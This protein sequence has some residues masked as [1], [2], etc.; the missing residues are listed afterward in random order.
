MPFDILIVGGG[1][2]GLT[3]AITLRAH[4]HHVTVLEKQPTL[5]RSAGASI[6]LQPGAVRVLRAYG[7]SDTFT[8]GLHQPKATWNWRRFESGEVLSKREV[9][10]YARTFGTESWSF[11]RQRL[12]AILVQEA[13]K[14]DINVT[15]GCKVAAIDEEK[16]AVMLEDGSELRADIIIGA[17][18]TSN[19]DAAYVSLGVR[20]YRY[21]KSLADE[22][23]CLF[24][25]WLYYTKM[26][27]T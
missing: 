1:I 23:I 13:L 14:A 24:R 25:Y 27:P 2:A 11:T 3:A 6:A 12:Q 16:P 15:V 10:Q 26:H 7:L 17:D 5:H 20:H 4:G 21:F 19:S 22:L 8:K 18:G 9:E